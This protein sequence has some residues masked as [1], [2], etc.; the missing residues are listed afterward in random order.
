MKIKLLIL[1]LACTSYLFAQKET[2]IPLKNSKSGI[3]ILQK[4]VDGFQLNF[5]ISSLNLKNKQ[6]SEGFFEELEVDGLT[7]VY[8]MGNPGIPSV[9]K[10]I[11]IPIGAT[12]KVNI[13]SYN[14]EV[15][16][17]NDFG[18]KEKIAP[19]QLSVSKNDDPKSVKFYYNKETYKQI[20]FIEKNIAT[21]EDIGIMRDTRLGRLELSPIQYN[22]GENKIK[23]FNNLVVEVNFS[24]S[25]DAN[26]ENSKYS[27][28]F[29][30][31]IEKNVINNTPSSKALLGGSPIKYIIISDP[32]FSTTLQPFIEWKKK[33]GFIVVEKYTNDAAVGNTTTSIKSYLQSQYTSSADGIPQTFLLLVGDVAQIP[34]F[35][36]TISGEDHITDLYYADYTNDNL[37]D[38]FYGRFSATSVAQLQPQVDKTLQVEQAQM[39]DKSYLTNVVLVAGVDATYAPTCGNGAINY[40]NQYYTNATNGINSYFYLYNNTSGVMA[41]NN[42]GAS[43]SIRDKINQGVSFVN[44]TAHCSSDGW[45]DPSFSISH[46]SGL[47][48]QNKYP[49]IIGNCCQS[50]KFELSS[51]AEE[52]LRAQNKGAVGYI[53]GSDYTYWDEDYW[54][55]VGLTSS[56][57][58]NPTYE[59]SGLGA[60]D[61]F[62]HLKGETETNWYITQGQMVVAGN[63]AVESSSSTRKKYYWE[64]YHLMGDPSLTPPVSVPT[65]LTATHP[66]SVTVGTSTF[67]VTVEKN[68]FVAL[69]M[70]G[71][72]IDSK[73]SNAS[74]NA[75][76]SLTKLTSSGT[77]DIVITKQNRTPYIAQVTVTGGVNDPQA[78]TT[79]TNL[80]ASNVAQTTLTLTWTASTDNIGVTGYDV[81]KNGS[82]LANSAST[83]Y[84]VAGL[85]A[86]TSYSFYVKAKDAAGNASAAS[87]TVN[88]TTLA[89]PSLSL[90]VTENF[91]SSTLPSQW[92]TQ[93]TGTGI[94]ERWSMSNTANAGGA[95]YELMCTYQQINPATTRII[96]PAVNT[97]GV[98]TVTFSFKHMLNA[99]AAGVT[100]RLQTSNDKSTWTNTSWSVA[101]TATD[102]A[103]TTVS[104]PVTTNLNSNTTYF[105]L[106]ADGDLY[107]IDYWYID[108][109]SI[110]SGGGST[111]PTVTTNTVSNITSTSATSGGNVTSDGG[112]TVT[113][114]GIC[115]ATTANPTTANSKV[116]S[117]T[118]TGTF[119]AT[120][121]GLT[122]ATY[123][124]RAYAINSNGTAY[125]SQQSFTTSTGGST[126][127]IGTGTSTQG[128][129]LSCYYGYE[130]SASL[131]T[132]AEVGTTGTINMVEWYPT[133]TL[134]YNVPV[135]IYIKTTT[136]TTITAS[137]WATAISGATL[138]YNGTMAGTTAS[139]WKAFSLS[140]P[141]NY[142]SNNVLVLV[143]TN[144][145]GTGAGT[146]TGPACR[147]TSATSKHMYIRADNS[148]PTGTA[149][150]SSYRPNIRVTFA[151]KGATLQNNDVETKS[152]IPTT[153]SVYPNPTFNSITIKVNN[154]TITGEAKIFNSIGALVKI[155]RMDSN[156]TTV[157]VSDLSSG[158]YIISMD[159]AKKPM[160]TRFVKK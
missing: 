2:S 53:G 77:L 124:V 116:T 135:K 80:A 1:L 44:Y 148:A 147:Y 17:L 82:F 25:T 118:G 112:A 9:S 6:T 103:A 76:L 106:V 27:S 115:Y 136:A 65:A 122:V 56:V 67:S 43:A 38:I 34:A 16:D 30:S 101:T 145:T 49:L 94:T 5:N 41:S 71:N 46:V 50:A 160:F 95:A 146:S 64:I 85:T 132:A 86:S 121:T 139:A 120:M 70:N 57:T 28:Y 96:T 152:E 109:I 29:Q 10:L 130:R 72:L 99:Y 8:S 79:P 100:L 66:S 23:V 150:V 21:I 153:I 78:P 74:N 114:R 156:E 144:Y 59:A 107:Q 62:F 39:P 36:G 159:D 33:M 42:S 127:T 137:T 110:T 87:N 26:K 51:F 90:P 104:V 149:T 88:V 108:N 13:I 55:G 98:S 22:P 40:A 52:I 151:P 45:S 157:D 117:G 84:N 91:A 126:V 105:A 97:V 75:T 131:Y 73:L 54:W 111:V 138:V 61:R 158:V 69:T 119:T 141:F 125:G 92:T 60:Y 3:E 93:N 140:T 63:L 143:E 81:Y 37:P 24:G 15:I 128:Y 129:P 19:A 12:Y 32:M 20:G 7:K 4:R 14:V 47:T 48:N 123:Y 35:P 18:I 58:A 11:E 154:E 155:V 113:E 89:I 133:I 142:T 68:S 102:I 31:I 134:S 83:T